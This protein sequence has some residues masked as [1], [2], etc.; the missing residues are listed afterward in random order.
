M[1]LTETQE[2]VVKPRL[3]GRFVVTDDPSFGGRVFYVE[4]G[5]RHWVV[6]AAYFQ[7]Y[8]F[9]WPDDLT[10]VTAQEIRNLKIGGQLPWPWVDTDM[11]NPPK[12]DWTSLREISACT[13]HGRGIEFGA[14]TA[15]FCIPPRCD[16]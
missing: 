12:K 11:H 7:A 2:R 1:H 15:P 14:G 13:L 4:S 16:V 8:G 10:K 5:I 9:Q 6:D 3:S